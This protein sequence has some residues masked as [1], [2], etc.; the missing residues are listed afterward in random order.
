MDN[1]PA[2]NSSLAAGLLTSHFW[3]SALDVISTT[4]T[5]IA[6]VTGA[7]IGM[8]TVYRMVRNAYLARTAL[9]NRKT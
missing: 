8:V 7:I 9:R 2:L 6:T 4:A 3:A 5:L 1:H